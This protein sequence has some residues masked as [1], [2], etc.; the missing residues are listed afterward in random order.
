MSERSGSWLSA[1]SFARNDG[2]RMIASRSATLL[3]AI[4]L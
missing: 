2:S 1:S 3:L 4:A